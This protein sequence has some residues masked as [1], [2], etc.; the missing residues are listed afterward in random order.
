[1][2]KLPEDIK[3]QKAAAET[4][5]H[6]LKCDLREKKP[7]EWV[8]PYS[9]KHFQCV[10]VEWVVATDQASIYFFKSIMISH[11]SFYPFTATLCL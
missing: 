9:D 5:M 1:V 8:V 2:S 6:T 3:R 11:I 10:A 7:F 4:A